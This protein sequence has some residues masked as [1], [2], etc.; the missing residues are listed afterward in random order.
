MVFLASGFTAPRFGPKLL[1]PEEGA[2]KIFAYQYPPLIDAQSPG[3]G[4][5]VNIVQAAFEEVGI[6]VQVEILP[7]KSIAKRSV[8][9]E[10]GVAMLG[11]AYLFSEAEMGKLAAVPC[12]RMTGVYYY[13]LPAHKEG[14]NWDGDLNRLKGYTYGALTGEDV[15]LYKKAGVKVVFGDLKSLLRKLKSKEIDFLSASE[16]V[17][18]QNIQK[19]YP[20]E[21]SNFSRMKAPAWTSTFS[22]F[23]NKRHPQAE[24]L[25]KAYTEGLDRVKQ[26]GK[27][28]RI[29]NLYQEDSHP[30]APEAYASGSAVA[31]VEFGSSD[32]PPF[33]SPDLP[34]DGMAGEI[35]H[36]IFS[37][38]NV[39][40]RI[41]YFPLKR[42]QTDLK[43]NHLGDPDN[44]AGQQFSA[45][46][47][48]AVYR[49]AFFY[50]RPLHKEGINYKKPEDL[51]KYTIGMIRG[52]LENRGYF[53][54]N[55]IKVI[56]ANNER[57]LFRQLQ[58]GRIDL[59]GVI[60]ETGEFIV[61]KEFPRE[62]RNFV[63][64]EIP[65]SVSPITV[66][67]DWN[68]PKGKKLGVRIGE[69]LTRI[70]KNGKYMQILEKYYGKG[71]IPDDFFA[72]LEKYRN[73]YRQMQGN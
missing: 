66:M 41:L 33:F 60:K 20:D 70:I 14:I 64:I 69:G 19:L 49:A 22:L 23:F 40:S 51:N 11:E 55:A 46:I 47:P 61:K 71:N 10:N 18:R 2:I 12:Y 32:T 37:E 26:S 8:L 56:E 68:Y 72:D 39:K 31:V 43:N 7:I 67:I 44:F 16:I 58:E 28:G 29:M 30:Q 54:K 59:C 27:Y 3:M 42:L 21:I 24:R 17:G 63:P 50:Y 15:S 65:K 45:I 57:S 6:E 53:D 1:K 9:Y 36:A 34:E 62:V 52:T 4:A 35:L 73:R 48:I 25:I 38:I 5:L 13:Y